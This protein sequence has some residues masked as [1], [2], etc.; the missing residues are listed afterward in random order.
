MVNM[1]GI[2]NC[3]TI[4][5][6]KRWLELH[7]IAYQFHDV[8]KEAVDANLLRQW[9]KHVSWQQLLNKRGLTWRGLRDEDKVELDEEKAISLLCQYPSM[10]KRP[11][12]LHDQG[13]T[14]GFDVALYQTLFL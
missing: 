6:T 9:L 2:P 4:K 5:K 13:V 3:D 1:Y 11:V 14:V 10:I 7:G 8:K 12:L